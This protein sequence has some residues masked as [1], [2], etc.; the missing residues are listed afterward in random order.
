MPVTPSDE[1]ALGLDH[2]RKTV[3]ASSTFQAWTSSADATAAL[4]HVYQGE[5]PDSASRPFA[6]VWVQRLGGN[7]IASGASFDF[8]N[9][10]VLGFQLVQTISSGASAEDAYVEML[11]KVGGIRKDMLNLAGTGT[12]YLNI[13]MFDVKSVFRY[14]EPTEAARGEMTFIALMEVTYKP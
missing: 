2:L 4:A 8:D 7:A 9:V 11:N 10:G 14:S 3:A 5:A 13:Q 12:P 6:V 1:L